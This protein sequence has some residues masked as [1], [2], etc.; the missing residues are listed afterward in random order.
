MKLARTAE[1]RHRIMAAL[2]QLLLVHR[3]NTV[4]EGCRRGIAD[5]FLV[6]LFEV[7]SWTEQRHGLVLFLFE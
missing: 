6:L 4:E 1:R 2:V 3:R 5:H 7:R